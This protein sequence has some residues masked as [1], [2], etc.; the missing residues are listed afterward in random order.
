MEFEMTG[1]LMDEI[2]FAMEDQT[3]LHMF[4][5]QELR[6]IPATDQAADESRF[7]SIPQWDS[8]SGFRMMERFVAQLRNPVVREELRL[9]LSSGHGVFRNFKNCLKNAPEVEKL[10]FQFK[11]RQMKNAVSDWY[12][13]LRDYW[14]I[15]RIGLEPED[16]GDI[17]QNDF[18]F[19]VFD[20]EDTSLIDGLVGSLDREIAE[21]LPV[22]L[23]DAVFE[24][25]NRI[26]SYRA[27]DD[28]I[29]VAENAEGE[30]SGLTVSC[31]LPDDSL[32]SAHITFIGVYPEYRG[33]GLGREL[34]SRTI[35]HWTEKGFRWLLFT[36]PVIPDLFLPVLD[37]FGFVSMGHMRA[38][39]LSKSVSH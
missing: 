37:R 23:S 10:W 15:E 31:P 2:I 13:S 11:D 7:Y 34:L 24:L 4:D 19:R 21:D 3:G 17:L 22:M 30:L 9:A 29:I 38:L 6:C 32:L 14:G 5:S 1:E 39:D 8:V 20:D 26:R 12:N 16:T 35:R 27:E 25:C 33:L 36:N 18:V 28:L